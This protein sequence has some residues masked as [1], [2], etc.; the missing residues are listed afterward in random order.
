MAVGS[1]RQ[2]AFA[3]AGRR[4]VRV[5]F[6]RRAL[7][8]GVVGAIG[9]VAAIW[10]FNP[11]TKRNGD[12]TFSSLGIDGTKVAIARPQLSGFKNDGQAYVLTAERALQDVKQPTRIELQKLTGEIGATA[13]QTTHISANAG[14]YDSAAENMRLADNIK[15]TNGRFEIRLQSA[16]IDFK[17]GRYRSDQPV[18]VRLDSGTT[19]VSDRAEARNNGQE[20]E[21]TGRVRTTVVP[22]SAEG[23]DGAKRDHP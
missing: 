10:V 14:V 1:D 21:F 17:T 22:Q 11:F 23:A 18:E 5:R 7:L 6:L 16:D 2:E 15:I 9:G 13:G 12:L 20:L 3:A 8:V 19:I 4:S